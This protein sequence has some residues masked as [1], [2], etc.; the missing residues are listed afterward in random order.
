MKHTPCLAPC[1]PLP[2]PRSSTCPVSQ[3]QAGDFFERLRVVADNGIVE[4]QGGA[5]DLK[6]EVV[7]G[8][9][10]YRVGADFDRNIYSTPR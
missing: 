6:I 8:A 2:T 9:A 3:L 4:H 5:S 7:D 1:S 10:G